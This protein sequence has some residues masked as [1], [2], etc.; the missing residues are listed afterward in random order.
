M[1]GR[2][3]TPSETVHHI[4]G[5]RLNNHPTNLQLRSGKHGNGVSRICGDCGSINVLSVELA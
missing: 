1:L 4:D 2:L 5:D 3:L